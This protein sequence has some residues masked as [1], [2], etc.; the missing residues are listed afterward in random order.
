MKGILN[1]IVF[2]IV[3][4]ILLGMVTYMLI[5]QFITGYYIFNTFLLLAI[6]LILIAADIWSILKIVKIKKTNKKDS[7]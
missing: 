3:Y 5:S 6:L 2:I 1:Y 7:K 4:T